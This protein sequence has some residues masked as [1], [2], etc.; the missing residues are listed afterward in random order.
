V[1]QTRD[2]RERASRNNGAAIHWQADGISE[3][4]ALDLRGDV[5]DPRAAPDSQ[6]V[7]VAVVLALQSK[8]TEPLVKVLPFHGRW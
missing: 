1:A 3:L 4:G 6:I 2:E 5:E 8:A 7:C